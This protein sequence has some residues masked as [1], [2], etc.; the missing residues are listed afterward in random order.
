MAWQYKCLARYI[1]YYC[2]RTCF[3]HSRV[4]YILD[5]NHQLSDNKFSSDPLQITTPH[6]EPM[7][8]RIDNSALG[9]GYH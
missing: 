1:F 4:Q 7:P 2:E 5:F 3:H 8:T 6:P 9:K